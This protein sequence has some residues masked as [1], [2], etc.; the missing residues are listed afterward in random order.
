MAWIILG[1]R[2]KTERVPDGLVVERRCTSCGERATFYE[3]KAVRTFRLYF[4]DVF[5]YDAQRVMACGA[6]GALY[7]T[8]EHGEP[9]T[10]TASGWRGAFA[11]AAGQV[12]G[13]AQK[14]G[15]A[16][17]PVWEQASENARELLEGARE[18]IG[19]IARKAG[20]GVGDAFRRLRIEE[21]GVHDLDEEEKLPESAREKDPYKADVLRR[22]EELERRLRA[23]D[24]DG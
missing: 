7:A 5:D 19:P 22:F 4:V 15:E 10:E 16:I 20:E 1:H 18:G 13:A 24:D 3:R 23:S 12:K 17:A 6:C 14:A 21:D 9:S 2:T 8:D 11:T